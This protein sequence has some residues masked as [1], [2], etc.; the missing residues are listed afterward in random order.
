M[1]TDLVAVGVDA[2]P[3]GWI[4]AAGFV[5]G[6][7]PQRTELIFRG[8]I[9]EID[10]WRE[11][12][13]PEA[14]L[15]VDIPI[16]VLADGGSRRCDNQVRSELRGSTSTVFPPPGRYLLE[17]ENAKEAQKLVAARKSRVADPETIPGVSAQ[18][19]GL[20]P[21]IRDVDQY[22]R[23]SSQDGG[24]SLGRAAL[25]E[26]H[27]EL[28]FLRMSKNE[29]LERKASAM[30][31]LRRMQLIGEFFDDFEAAVG[32]CAWSAQ[33][34]LIDILDAYAALWTS[35]RCARRETLEVFGEGDESDGLP[36]EIRV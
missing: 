6:A 25:F 34:S 30:G 19:A 7:K 29:P 35:L 18:S 22:L 17:A 10:D 31:Q 16:G 24:R 33:G 2:A 5:S 14:P 21:R 26:V 4:A 28:C 27:P 13:G 15:A 1:S 11:E 32:K 8:T 36:A 3:R 12:R 20:I 9:R 23:R